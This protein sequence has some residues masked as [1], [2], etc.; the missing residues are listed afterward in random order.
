MSVGKS[1][2]N[3]NVI[4]KMMLRCRCIL[5]WGE[6]IVVIVALVINERYQM[7]RPDEIS[8]SDSTGN[9]KPS[10]YKHVAFGNQKFPTLMTLGGTRF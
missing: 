5:A 3:C 10:R 2:D 6:S 7:M 4:V 1:S 8:K 9:G